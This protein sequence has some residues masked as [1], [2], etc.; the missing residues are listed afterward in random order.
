MATVFL[1]ATIAAIAWLIA[2]LRI[3]GTHPHAVDVA[4]SM[5]WITVTIFWAARAMGV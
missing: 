1:P 2:L 3:E 5:Y 4:I